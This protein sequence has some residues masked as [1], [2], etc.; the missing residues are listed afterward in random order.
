LVCRFLALAAASLLG[1]CITLNPTHYGDPWGP[2]PNLPAPAPQPLIP[3]MRIV[4]AVGWPAQGAP[5][6][7]PGFTVTRYA[8]GMAHP[9][10]LYVL[11]NG[12]VLVSEATTKPLHGGGVKT[13]IMHMMKRRGGSLGDSADR[14]TLLRDRDGDGVV[15]ERSV[16]LEGLNQPLGMAL[17]GD[18]LY[19]ANTDAVMA[20]PY[21]PGATRIDAP[22]RRIA[23]LPHGE[24][25]SSPGHWTRNLLLSPDGS[26]LYVTIGSVSN[27]GED[28]LDREQGRGEIREIDLATGAVRRYANGLRNPNG[29]AW[30]PTTGALWAVVSERDLMGDDAPPDYM[31]AVKEGGFYGWPWSYWGG[32]VDP[33][34]KPPRPELT[35]RAIT[36]DYALGAHTA[37]LGIAFYQGEA[38]PPAWRGGAFIAQHGSW[39]R[40]QPAGYRIVFVPFEGGR[41]SGPARD[42]LTGFLAP[43]NR[44]W[45]RPVDVAVDATGAL[46]VTDDAGD[47]VWRVA[48][49]R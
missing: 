20:F 41:P 23:E 30:E 22:G 6:A 40:P 11:P 35:A 4:R 14:I 13:A 44:A 8:E 19:V 27:I 21:A 43:G 28:G 25:R 46:L 2:Q 3:T 26:K 24:G 18:T 16:F 34:V 31:T 1:G 5:T 15:D 45:G 37:S 48:P 47:M 39:N 38:F 12:D 33:R 10:W 32:H 9:R 29:L 42:F 7:P 49:S 17:R 36:P